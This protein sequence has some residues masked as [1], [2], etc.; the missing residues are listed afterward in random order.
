[1]TAEP[2]RQRSRAAKNPKTR[3]HQLFEGER[4]AERGA[5]PHRGAHRLAESGAVG[6]ELARG[7]R[8]NLGTRGSSDLREKLGAEIIREKNR[9]AGARQCKRFTCKYY[10]WIYR[11]KISHVNS[12]GTLIHNKCKNSTC[13]YY[14]YTHS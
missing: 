7:L 1:M 3:A 9:R 4:S 5:R 13:K 8:A 14:L 11:V 6:G 12:I 10:W 2:E